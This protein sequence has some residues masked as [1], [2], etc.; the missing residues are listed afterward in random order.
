[1]K[2]VFF[3]LTLIFVLL[4]LSFTFLKKEL[5]I[6]KLN[7]ISDLY[8]SVY[9][10]LLH[11]FLDEDIIFDN[12]EV[13]K[14]FNSLETIDYVEL[15]PLYLKQTN[16]NHS[17]FRYLRK[18]TYYKIYK[19]DLKKR[20]S[21]NVLIADLVPTKDAYYKSCL[22]NNE[23]IFLLIN[24]KL[25]QK[26]IHLQFLL[27]ENGYDHSAFKVLSGHR[28]PSYN[29]KVGGA[30]LSR[31]IRGEAVDIRIGD[32]DKDGRYTKNDK[33][34]VL[35]LLENNVIKSSG[36]IGRYPNTRSIHFDVR[37]YR[38]RWDVY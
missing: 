16:S 25:V 27:K 24:K 2:S 10:S 14:L 28:Y 15:D 4:S 23:P 12:E 17:K 20:I 31:H 7:Y 11:Y 33:K 6:R 22:L 35:D 18:K 29:K 36:G 21:G 30:I 19:K 37:G 5:I 9:N 34:I 32:I 13:N 38:A 26:L 3:F 8:P 1:M